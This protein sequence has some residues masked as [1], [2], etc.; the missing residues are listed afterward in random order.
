M[1]YLA[2]SS[3]YLGTLALV[4]V[5]LHL[6]AKR[7]HPLA[8]SIQGCLD[9]VSSLEKRLTETE[10]TLARN[11]TRAKAELEASVSSEAERIRGEI[12]A[13]AV[14]IGLTKNGAPFTQQNGVKPPSPGAVLR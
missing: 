8:E 13:F 10:D 3:A 12:N 14:G 4:A 1:I 2:L 6:R 7:A 5:I 9:K 11:Y